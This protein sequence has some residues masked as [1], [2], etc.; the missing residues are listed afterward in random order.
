VSVVGTLRLLLV[1]ASLASSTVRS[2]FKKIQ[3]PM[4][5]NITTRSKSSY[6]VISEKLRTV[7]PKLM[8]VSRGTA[9]EHP[10]AS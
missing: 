6:P 5:D 4:L 1:V 3:Q 9:Q 10:K 8:N 2:V 7:S